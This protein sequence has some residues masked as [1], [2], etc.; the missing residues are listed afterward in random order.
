M[1]SG[2]FLEF[3][4]NPFVKFYASGKASLESQVPQWR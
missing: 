2:L 1:I 4:D 3:I